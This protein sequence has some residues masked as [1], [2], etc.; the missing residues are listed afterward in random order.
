MG[1]CALRPGL[2][3]WNVAW[4]LLRKSSGLGPAKV[5]A[6]VAGDAGHALDS[7]VADGTLIRGGAVLDTVVGHG[8]VV[9]WRWRTWCRVVAVASDEGRACGARWW[10]RG[11]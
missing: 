1:P 3:L 6:D 5:V 4:P 11:R 10:R 9:G 2:D 8:V 7:L